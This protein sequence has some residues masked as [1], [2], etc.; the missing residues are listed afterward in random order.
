[1]TQNKK[2]MPMVT[3]E[4]LPAFTITYPQECRSDEV[5]K[6]FEWIA[7]RLGYTTSGNHTFENGQRSLTFQKK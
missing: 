2:P 5:D 6:Y 4:S 1:M 3:I 7:F